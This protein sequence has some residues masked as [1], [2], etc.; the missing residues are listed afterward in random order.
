GES[1][2]ER[3]AGI[4]DRLE[5]VAPGADR[6]D[7]AEVR[8]DVSTLAL[9]RMAEGAGRLLAEEDLAAARGRAA[10]Q[11]GLPFR[12]PRRLNHPIRFQFLQD[13]LGPMPDLRRVGFQ[14]LA[15]RLGRE[16]RSPR[17]TGP[18]GAPPRPARAGASPP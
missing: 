11:Q 2:S 3:G 7:L 8:T 18:R 17:R 9:G 12:Q 10:R 13:R 1:A 15:D 4:D 14:D 6:A 16:A 5:Q